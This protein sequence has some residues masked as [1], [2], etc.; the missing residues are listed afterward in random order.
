MIK[1][2]S[3]T[4][5]QVSPE[6]LVKELL[7]AHR[8]LVPRQKGESIP[9]SYFVV[10]KLVSNLDTRAW[11]KICAECL[12]EGWYTLELSDMSAF[13]H[14]ANLTVGKRMHSSELVGQMLLASPFLLQTE[15]EIIRARRA[16]TPLALARFTFGDVS[17]ANTEHATHILHDAV[18]VHG[19]ICDTL[20]ILDAQNFALILPSAK[21]FKAQ[22]V[23]ENILDECASQKLRLH[24]GIAELSREN[25][26]VQ[27][28]LKNAGEA[29]QTALQ[30]RVPL[31]MYKKTAQSL[32]DTR[33]LV[34]SHEKRFL[35]GGGD[36]V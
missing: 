1:N 16:T 10:A 12:P 28:L 30:D 24:A 29:L 14:M 5:S 11:E 20:G 25:C 2:N 9:P 23:V 33:T 21:P 8:E 22:S 27:C 36:E 4:P 18:Q 26:N 6:A 13:V 32:D 7:Q 3:S 34:L 35:F 17:T 15:K 31:R 19:D